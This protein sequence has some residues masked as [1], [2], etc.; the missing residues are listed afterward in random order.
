ML[1]VK[2]AL[3]WF[4]QWLQAK[5]AMGLAALPNSAFPVAAQM[6]LHLTRLGAPVLRKPTCDILLS[7][8]R[9]FCSG[10][11]LTFPGNSLE[12]ILFVYTPLSPALTITAELGNKVPAKIPQ[13][14]G[15]QLHQDVSLWEQNLL[16][17]RKQLLNTGGLQCLAMLVVVFC[18]HVKLRFQ[19]FPLDSAVQKGL[20][21][22]SCEMVES[23]VGLQPFG[24][25]RWSSWY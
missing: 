12:K 11:G 5:Q 25:S 4:A 10:A 23:P 6:Q 15:T 21:D 8:H 16:V 20:P 18:W 13:G 19:N 24:R 14:K 22:L 3:H 7:Q 1:V 17:R 9:L 2:F